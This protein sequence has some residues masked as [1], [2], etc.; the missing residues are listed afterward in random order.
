MFASSSCCQLIARNAL[1]VSIPILALTASPSTAQSI[2]AAPDGTGTAIT[3]NGNTYTINGGT[4]AGAN[5]FHSFQQFGLTPQETAHFLSNPSIRNV[6]GRV[7][8][9][10]P[11]TI[12]GLIRLTGGNSNLYLINPAGI[13]FTQG[14][15]LDLPSSFAATTATRIGFDGG[16]FNATGE[17]DYAALTG[18]PTHLIFDT[19]TGSILN[20]GTLE[21]AE[22]QSLWLVGS[23]VL[24]T[25][26]LKAPGG[27]VTIAAIPGSKQIRIRQD[28]ML[29][30][31][32][33][34]A[35][36]TEEAEGTEAVAASPTGLQPA[37]LPR[38]LAGGS[39]LSNANAVTVGQDGTIYLSSNG[40]SKEFQPGD[41][42]IAGSVE[43]DTVQLMAA[44][45]VTATDY[46]LVQGKTT[47]VRFPEQASDPL[48]LAAIDT[49]VVDYQHFLF[50]GTP[51]TI[52]FTVNPNESGI[53][54]IGNRLSTIGESGQQADAIHIIS[55]GSAGNFWLGSDFVSHEN[56]G[57]Y[58]AQLQA[59]SVNLTTAADVLLY[60]CLTAL[61]LP[62][63]SLIQG[64]ADAT[65]A[66]VAASTTVTGSTALGGD[67]ILEKSTGTIEAAPGFTADTLSGY[68]G[69]LAIFT[70]TDG[71]DTGAGTL[72]QAI[73][74]ANGLVGADEIRFSGVTL[75]DLTSAELGIS[76]ELT[77]TGGAT[78]VRVQRN[79]GAGN[80]RIF[81]V[82]G[83]ATTTFDNLTITN[84]RTGDRGGG[85]QS[86]GEVNL[87]RSTVSGNSSTDRGGGIYTNR[88]VTLTDSTI[89]GNSTNQ[90][91]GGIAT[92][93]QITVTNST[94][95]GN[96]SRRNGAGLYSRSGKITLTDSTV[97]GNSSN[98]H[99]GGV[100]ARSR[101]ITL[102]RSTVSGNSSRISAAGTYSQ[103][104]HITDSVV[105]GNTAGD[106][107]GGVYF[108]GTG[109]ITNST[110][111]GNSSANKGGG[112]YFRN[113]LTI[114]N[115]TL[116][117]N[118]SNRGGGIYSRGGGT[119]TITN[120][121]LSGNSSTDR[122][123]GIFARGRSGGT[124][125]VLNSTIAN[126][127]AGRDGGGVFRNAGTVNLSNTIVA[128][129][130]ANRSGNDLSGTFN[131]VENSLIGDTL[132]ATITTSTN[133][134]T[135]VD[136]GL[137][138]LG[139]YGGD[140]QTHALRPDS[141]A[142][143]AGNNALATGLTTD[144]RG[145]TRIFDGTVDIGAY[146]SHGFSLLPVTSPAPVNRNATAF[147]AIDASMQVVEGAFS[148]PI[149]LEG[150]S[151]DYSLSNSGVLGAF[152]SGTVV[153][154]AQGFATNAFNLTGFA[155]D[156]SG[157]FQIIGTPANVASFVQQVAA[158]SI[159]VETFGSS[160]SASSASSTSSLNSLD[161]SEFIGLAELWERRDRTFS[162]VKIPEFQ[163]GGDVLD[164]E[165][166]SEAL[167]ETCASDDVADP[168][169][170]L[171]DEPPSGGFENGF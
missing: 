112:M 89:S 36:P 67:W 62:G 86:N 131:T 78:N 103:T 25:G 94:V 157:S 23:S 129:N 128:T 104:I 146:E 96:S 66:D 140:T 91:G 34:E 121:T 92:R 106:L 79:A 83:G 138:A 1:V 38:Y 84:G 19:E 109:N 139:D 136:P 147:A 125:T 130:V 141:P 44:G 40:I 160:T 164:K 137:F 70:V 119:A 145:A 82:T 117:G 165:S 6:L 98:R 73:S 10:N 162:C 85:I 88:A 171:I 12:E 156:F 114:A 55:E 132:G 43:A 166:V 154:N 122:G 51:G 5:L 29:L 11:S 115:S 68:Q 100:W 35:I 144:Q 15:S 135:G 24:N 155:D 32:V 45:Q 14:A 30:D 74:D 61:G 169:N 60:S 20:Q 72:R 4:Q 151:V 111:S 46:D 163:I 161:V 167:G 159:T 69:K 17:N 37:D 28:N 48:A 8:G 54:A 47:V 13:V 153:T 41:V 42:G 75:V 18:N 101:T 87:T 71:G 49:T 81:N 39:E 148:K 59:W 107:G 77:I 127:T 133:N 57:Q 110:I 50:G 63:D 58:E 113:N 108:T 118:S 170:R 116:S 31:L 93:S 97:S 3:H 21:V 52:A 80:F 53:A 56:L 150:L 95:S 149:P 65:G 102:T 7:V 158:G 142:L 120:T 123:G 2:T 99:G 9:G 105:S 22:G 143:N 134:L 168:S 33:V 152:D 16:F 27:N 76:D 126:N 64:I 26:T 124:I 90:Y